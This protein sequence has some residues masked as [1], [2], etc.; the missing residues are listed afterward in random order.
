MIRNRVRARA[1]SSLLIRGFSQDDIFIANDVQLQVAV[2]VW[3]REDVLLGVGSDPEELTQGEPEA[4]GES[5][6]P[7]RLGMQSI[8]LP[9]PGEQEHFGQLPSWNGVGTQER[10]HLAEQLN[11]GCDHATPCNEGRVQDES[12]CV[13]GLR[14]GHLQRRGRQR[15][16]LLL[17]HPQHHKESR[18]THDTLPAEQAIEEVE[19]EGPDLRHVEVGQEAVE[20]L[21]YR[22]GGQ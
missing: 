8:P 6:A 19:D 14:P 15:R 4:R 13:S 3:G 21:L 7:R 2:L 12:E 20:N 18:H 1:T 5:Q 10:G 16:D 22:D 9:A 17:L 11:D